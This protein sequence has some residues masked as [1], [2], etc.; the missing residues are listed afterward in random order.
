MLIAG[1]TSGD[2]LA[3]ELVKALGRSWTEYATRGD[4]DDLKFFGAGGSNMAA[5]GV[6]LAFDLT[7]HSVIG[8]WEVIKKYGKFRKLFN[9]LLALAIERRPDVIIGVD[10][11]GFNLRFA[12]AI[13]QHLRNN[14]P[15]WR[16]KLVQLVSPQ[17]WASRPGRAK[18][19]AD[20][21]DLV[22]SILPFEKK[23]YA[24]H[25]P[26]LRV[27]FVGH[28]IIDRHKQTVGR[29]AKERVDASALNVLILPGS[30]Q[31]ELRRHLPVVIGAGERIKS[32]LPEARFRMVLPEENLRAQAM[33]TVQMPEWIEVQFGNLAEALEDATVA[34]ASTGTV[35]ME[36]ALFG[37]PTVA[38]YKT[39]WSTYQIGRRLVTVPFLA[40]PNILA[41]AMIFPE[42][43]Q[44]EATS[45]NVSEAALQLLNHPEHRSTVR[46]KLAGII[47][48]LGPPG[49]VD[50]AAAKVLELLPRQ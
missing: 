33:K 10:F 12:R 22:L 31:S 1:E 36:C 29:E 24:E 32:A 43:I 14:K 2:L 48:N 21:H 49:A 20:N 6:E 19:I 46:S 37:V 5:A 41:G 45:D 3:A 16:P 17:V 40:M 13:R 30:R 15:D 18:I 42:F 11:G 44:N 34:I 4:G 27:E 35:T 39:S 23:W 8:L 47:S 50:R 9:Q 26:G 7:Q 28:P 25:V 38:L